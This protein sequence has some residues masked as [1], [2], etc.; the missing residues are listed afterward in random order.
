M[1]RAIFFDRDGVI[2]K[3]IVEEGRPFS[4]RTFE[5]FE[6][7]DNIGDLLELC[8][9]EGFLNII[10]TNQPDISR[11]LIDE[12]SLR[13]MHKFIK[14]NM[15]VDDI[16]VCPHTDTDN[17]YC[18][19]PKPGML[20]AAADKWNIDLN[21]SFLIGD[22]WKDM[23]A[24]RNAGCTTILID[25]HYNKGVDSDFRIG[26]LSSAIEIFLKSQEK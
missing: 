17:C 5:E 15:S 13:K 18:R 9:K 16:L 10:I 8:R 23:E 7:V 6:L 12:N 25:C 1:K 3:A 24:G 19:K 21:G 4:P 14:K 11:G 20:L 26:D 2:N 22:Q